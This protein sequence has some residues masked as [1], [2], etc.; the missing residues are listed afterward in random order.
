MRF[1]GHATCLDLSKTFERLYRVFLG[2]NV[3]GDCS[4][5]LGVDYSAGYPSMQTMPSSTRATRPISRP[6]RPLKAARGFRY[7]VPI[8]FGYGPGATFQVT[9][10]VPS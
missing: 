9:L 3:R 5:G 7:E 4:R 10:G 1:E 8:P 2:T 6:Q